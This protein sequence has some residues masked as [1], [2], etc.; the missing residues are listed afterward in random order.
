MHSLLATHC[1][2]ATRDLRISC[3]RTTI[4][5]WIFPIRSISS[6]GYNM[7][8]SHC[9]CVCT[10]H[11]PVSRCVFGYEGTCVHTEV[12]GWFPVAS[13]ALHCIDWGRV[14]PGEPP[15]SRDVWL[16]HARIP[17]SSWGSSCLLNKH[18]FNYL[19]SQFICDTWAVSLWT[20]WLFQAH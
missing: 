18:L 14:L 6:G 4:S 10:V 17:R 13:I 19:P 8:F 15:C 11:V 16:P 1:P 20:F 2:L 3:H 12:Q 7:N 5:G 9:V